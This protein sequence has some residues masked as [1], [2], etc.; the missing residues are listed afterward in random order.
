MKQKPEP[1]RSQCQHDRKGVDIVLV[2]IPPAEVFSVM[3]FFWNK[4]I[5]MRLKNT[6]ILSLIYIVDTSKGKKM[7]QKL[8]LVCKIDLN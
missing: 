6:Y 5:L 7:M 2:S 8:L 3:R 1:T 4:Q